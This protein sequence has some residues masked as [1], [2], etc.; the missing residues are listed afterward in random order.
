M[1][2][3]WLT[4]K[5]EDMAGDDEGNIEENKSDKRAI[6]EEEYHE[7]EDGSRISRGKKPVRQPG[8]EEYDEH[9]RTQI[10]F[11]KWCPHCVRAS[12]KMTRARRRRSQR[13]R[14]SQRCDGII[15]AREEEMAE[16][17]RRKMAGI[18]SSLV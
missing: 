15:W 4:K 6:I 16:L 8:R 18:R 7:K 14:K 2:I 17:L 3:M 5:V 10:P 1:Y 9:M 13:S 11:R 12:V